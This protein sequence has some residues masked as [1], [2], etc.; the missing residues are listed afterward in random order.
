MEKNDIVIWC[1]VGTH[2]ILVAGI[3]YLFK[4]YVKSQGENIA[5]HSR[6]IDEMRDC[7]FWMRVC[8]EMERSGG[9]SYL[10]THRRTGKLIVNSI[11]KDAK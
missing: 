1:L 3:V 5:L 7:N 6:L 11:L 10:L 9:T 2:L 4:R 8:E